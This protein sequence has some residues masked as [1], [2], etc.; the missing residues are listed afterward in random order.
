MAQASPSCFRLLRQ[1]AAWDPPRALLSTGQRRLAKSP[2]TA[3]TTNSSISENAGALDLRK[4][5]ETVAFILETALEQ[6][7]TQIGSDLKGACLSHTA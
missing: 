6:P 4:Q 5:V 2:T 1:T 7:W 3:M